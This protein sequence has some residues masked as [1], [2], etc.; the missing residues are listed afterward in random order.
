MSLELSADERYFSLHKSDRAQVPFNIFIG[1]R[2]TGKTFSSLTRAWQISY[3]DVDYWIPKGKF[4]YM[5]TTA[6]EAE[7]CCTLQGN[8]FKS[9]NMY[10]GQ[11][12]MDTTC[13][14]NNKLGIGTFTQD[15]TDIGYMLALAT[16]GRVRSIDFSDVT[17]LIWEEFLIQK[18]VRKLNN[19]DDLFFNLYET[20][21]RNRELDRLNP[22]PP[23]VV[24]FLTNST[25]LDSP[26][27]DVF[28]VPERY[29][30]IKRKS[31][32][33]YTDRE[34][35]VHFEDVKAQ[36]S[37]EKK[38]TALYRATQG[39]KFYSHAIDNEFAYES[40]DYILSVDLRHY[41]PFIQI[42]D[43]FIWMHKQTD[44]LHFCSVCG[45]CA[46]VYAGES[47]R[48]FMV[49]Y[50]VNIYKMI[51][52]GKCTFDDYSTKAQIYDLYKSKLIL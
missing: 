33:A 34:R 22:R 36:I 40:F 45:E 38:N 51:I 14:Y 41:K 20:I 10:Y 30:S 47:I 17:L 31:Q 50:G 6:L 28:G 27:L 44:R 15:E 4:I 29:E 42:N 24:Y 49:I 9:L 3:D 1:G 12:G 7:S 43:I 11:Q 2:G 26:V 19:T 21:N 37:E 52:Q 5:R 13:R 16:S 8:P 23:L 46:Y 18:G 35:G 32:T 39:T 48:E 25:T